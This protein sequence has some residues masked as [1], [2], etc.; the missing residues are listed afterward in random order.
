MSEKMLKITVVKSANH[1]NQK[2][3]ATM[4]ALGIKKMHKTVT[5]P[6]NPAV[7]GMVRKLDFMLKV[8]EA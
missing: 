5:R 1:R 3:I 6:N 2:Q 7:R 4:K 8:E